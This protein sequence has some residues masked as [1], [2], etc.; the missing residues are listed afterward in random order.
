MEDAGKPKEES[1]LAIAQEDPVNLLLSLLMTY[2]LSALL[3][4]LVNLKE[5]V[6]E[7]ATDYQNKLD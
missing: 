4:A 7:P 5:M 6:W 3:L 1:S 2:L